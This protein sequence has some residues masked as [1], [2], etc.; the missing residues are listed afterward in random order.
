MLTHQHQPTNLDS[1]LYPIYG[2]DFDCYYKDLGTTTVGIVYEGGVILGADCRSTS[3]TYVANRTND[4]IYPL[5]KNIVACKAGSAADT[6]FILGT[7]VKYLT[8]FSL[9]YQGVIPVKVAANLAGKI[10]YEYKDYFSASLIIGGVDDEG[11]HIY[12]IN[13]GSI[14]PQ[15]I[16]S[17][18]SGSF[19][20]SGFLDLNYQPNFNKE[21]AINFV[22]TSISLAIN[23]DNSSGGGI[24]ICDVT[25]EGFKRYEFSYNELDFQN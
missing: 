7:V 10:T 3:G 20:I 19:F 18:G 15:K 12:S 25:K 1:I 6:Q 2:K 23:R 5:A 8:Q 14:I 24:R 17:S 22:K 11:Q 21:Q 9:E 16:T 13:S 4:K